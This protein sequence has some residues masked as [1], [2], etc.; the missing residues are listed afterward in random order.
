MTGK[1]SPGA[2][3]NMKSNTYLTQCTHNLGTTLELPRSSIKN[4]E[5]CQHCD[6]LDRHWGENYPQR[7]LILPTSQFRDISSLSRFIQLVL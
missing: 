6:V 3:K 4:M 7:P 1:I 5:D 2:Q